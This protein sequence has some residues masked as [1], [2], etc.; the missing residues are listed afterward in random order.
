LIAY[1]R[2]ALPPAVSRALEAVGEEVCAALD[3]ARDLAVALDAHFATRALDISGCGRL[4]HFLNA[5]LDDYLRRVKSTLIARS[6]L[7]L[8]VTIRGVNWEHVDFR[9]RRAVHDPDSDYTATR[10]LLD[11]PRRSSTCR[12]IRTAARTI[13]FCVHRAD[14]P[15]S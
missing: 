2:E 9:G 13:A 5:Q 6:L 8:P 12:R 14:I 3:E 11:A 7:D 10:S 15:L 1:W 4:R